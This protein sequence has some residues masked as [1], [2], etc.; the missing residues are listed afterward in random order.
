MSRRLYW[1]LLF[2]P[3]ILLPMSAHGDSLPRPSTGA[4]AEEKPRATGHVERADVTLMLLDVE[5]IDK[6]GTP[7][8]GLAKKDF[9]VLLDGRPWPVYSV[10]DSCSCA[11]QEDSNTSAPPPAAGEAAGPSAPDGDR[12]GDAGIRSGKPGNASP[13]PGEV[14]T[15]G[16]MKYVIFIDFS[17]LQFAGR[18]RVRGEA[19]RWIRETMEPWDSVMITA[20]ATATG[21][22]EVSPFTSDKD[23]LLAAL[24]RTYEGKTFLDDFPE[25][26]EIRVRECESFP[27]LCPG[28]AMEEYFHGRS[29]LRALKQL[30]EFLEEVPGRKSLLLFHENGSMQ[31]GVFYGASTPSQLATIE[32]V[33]AAAN[34]S[35]TAV[36]L[37]N[38]GMLPVDVGLGSLTERLERQV[39]D[40]AAPLSEYTGGEYNLGP[41]DRSRLIDRV[42]R[43]CRCLYRLGLRPPEKPDRNIHQVQIRAAGVVL[44]HA[45]RVRFLTDADRWMRKAQ[46]ILRN[47]A[48]AKEIDLV[49]AIVPVA[50]EGKS[51]KVSLEVAVSSDTLSLIPDA[52]GR[53]ASYEIGALLQAEDGKR[54]WELL[55]EYKVRR[56]PEG[57]TDRLALQRKE[58]AGLRPGR[59]RLAAFIR[60][61]VSNLFGGAEA[62]IDL[63]PPGGGT[64]GPLV[65]LASRKRIVTPL[66]L[67]NEKAGDMDHASQAQVGPVPPGAS[68]IVRGDPVTVDTWVCPPE[69]RTISKVLRFVVRD[70]RP[71]FRFEDTVP[72][73]AGR[74]SLFSDPLDTSQLQAGRYAYHLQ[75]P[76]GS[77]DAPIDVEASFDV[78]DTNVRLEGSV[79]PR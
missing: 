72:A 58:L 21:L 27:P 75:S 45:Y 5:A 10:D 24:D 65:R 29:A 22:K 69:G 6:H 18:L 32:E 28:Y 74:C 70:G 57:S 44:P 51:W 33:A 61:R 15:A 8:R 40:L 35:R 20:Y 60:D 52:T 13:S 64:A 54:S 42:G 12:A 62:R 17:Q 31:P 68:G 26:L 67:V 55:G 9:S 76:P 38:V 2:L 46:A 56:G 19:T 14:E 36:Y 11:E 4:G 34:G 49:A 37:V 30:L 63:P 71:I 41:S 50:S 23:A 1:S 66:P 77:G 78:L 47:P 39:L 7:L 16:S 3:I 48:G 79:D 25:L 59:Y 53:E 43:G 73:R